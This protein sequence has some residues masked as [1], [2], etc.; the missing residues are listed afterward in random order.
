MSIQRDLQESR[1]ALAIMAQQ[2]AADNGDPSSWRW[3]MQQAMEQAKENIDTNM[4]Q[5]ESPSFTTITRI[6]YECKGEPSCAW[7]AGRTSK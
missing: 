1:E 6:G 7:Q 5:L 3:L 4:P 2:S